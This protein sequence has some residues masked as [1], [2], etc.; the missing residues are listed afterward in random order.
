[1]TTSVLIVDD[2]QSMRELV[3]MA[4][5]DA[6]VV[7]GEYEAGADA[8]GTYARLQP[9]WVLMDIEMENMDDIEATRRITAAYPKARVLILTDHDDRALRRAALEAGAKRYVVKENLLSIL[10]I[11]TE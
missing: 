1:M 7:V 10:E 3:R 11:L 2:S 9:D 6:A 8:L 5:G 4:L